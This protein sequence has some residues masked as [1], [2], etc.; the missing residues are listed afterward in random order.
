METKLPA[1]A[2]VWSFARKVSSARVG[3]SGWN[4]KRGGAL[5]SS[6]QFP[7]AVRSTPPTPA[8]RLEMGNSDQNRRE[9]EIE[10][11]RKALDAETRACLQVRRQL[12]RA[13]AEFEELD[14]KSVV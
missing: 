3:G 7:T 10:R 8:R 2:S 9:D 6:S 1:P 11:L 5:R 13:S 12:D 14:R 4:R